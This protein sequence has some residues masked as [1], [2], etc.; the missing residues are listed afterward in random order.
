[1]PIDDLVCVLL[2]VWQMLL[3]T[4]AFEEASALAAR[5]AVR[6]ID[7]SFDIEQAKMTSS[8]LSSN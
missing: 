8:L 7:R 6:S 2:A 4:H 3:T 1:V 5:I